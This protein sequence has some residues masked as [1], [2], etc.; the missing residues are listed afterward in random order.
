MGATIRIDL[1]VLKMTKQGGC[2]ITVLV[3]NE[4]QLHQR[5]TKKGLL[6]YALISMQNEPNI[7]CASSFFKQKAWFK[8]EMAVSKGF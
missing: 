5:K 4:I 7:S 1:D 3:Q 6:L 8:L 2:C